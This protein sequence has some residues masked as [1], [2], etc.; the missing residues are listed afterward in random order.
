MEQRDVSG[1][2]VRSFDP[3]TGISH[4]AW[5]GVEHVCPDGHPNPTH[6]E[7]D[8]RQWLICDRCGFA[9]RLEVRVPALPE[10]P[11]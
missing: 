11:A 3:T 2:A 6:W 5:F 1:P 4:G 8:R 7:G 9:V 10:D